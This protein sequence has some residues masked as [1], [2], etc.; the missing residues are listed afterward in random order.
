MDKFTLMRVGDL[1]PLDT[2]PVTGRAD[3][4]AELC[5]GAAT[6]LQEIAEGKTYAGRLDSASWRIA[7]A[8]LLVAQAAEA[9]GLERIPGITTPTGRG[10]RLQEHHQW[11]VRDTPRPMLT[12]VN[13]A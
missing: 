3:E 12:A 9:A 11:N 2:H 7:D 10:A 13:C 6:L 1:P 8:L 5:R 4:A